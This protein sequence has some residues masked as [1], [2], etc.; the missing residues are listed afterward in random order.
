MARPPMTGLVPPVR[1]ALPQ[2]EA[3]EP[4]RSSGDEAGGWSM[5]VG[6][7]AA[8]VTITRPEQVNGAFTTTM[9][10]A[11]TVAFAILPLPD[12]PPNLDG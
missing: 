3:A 11:T 9:A 4:E 2:G 8:A 1:V 6:I 10:T 5:A 12:P 7:S